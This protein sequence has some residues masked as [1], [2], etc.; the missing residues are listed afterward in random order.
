MGALGL[1]AVQSLSLL[2]QSRHAARFAVSGMVGGVFLFILLGLDPSADTVAHLGGFVGGLLI[3]AG[4]ALLPPSILEGRP[5]NVTTVL[6][7]VV[8]FL[9]TWWR[10][11]AAPG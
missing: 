2:R 9:F 7:A 1:V 3:G 10:A 11:L 6:V 8:V 5:A 4:L